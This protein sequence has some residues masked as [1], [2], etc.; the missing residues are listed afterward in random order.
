MLICDFNKVTFILLKITSLR[1]GCSVNLLRVFRTPFYE[2]TLY[3]T[4]CN[5][6]LTDSP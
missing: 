6:L 1:H 4:F 3:K 5:F 2:N